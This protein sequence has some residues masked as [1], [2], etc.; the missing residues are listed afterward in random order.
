MGPG[1]TAGVPRPYQGNLT[2]HGFDEG[3]NL[4][5]DRLDRSENWENIPQDH[6]DSHYWRKTFR[7]CCPL[8]STLRRSQTMGWTGPEPHMVM[9]DGVIDSVLNAIFAKI[10]FFSGKKYVWKSWGRG[11]VVVLWDALLNPKYTYIYRIQE[12]I[13]GG[14]GDSPLLSL[15]RGG[16]PPWIL[17]P[18]WA[19]RG[20]RGEDKFFFIVKST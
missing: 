6:S 5:Y 12:W 17:S 14:L 4:F 2:S 19:L 15:F 10:S 8:M 3:T 18:T 20:E 11:Q 13:Q 9:C 7:C 1:P 16:R